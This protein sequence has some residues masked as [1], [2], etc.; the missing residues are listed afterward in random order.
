[1]GECATGLSCEIQ[2]QWSDRLVLRSITVTLS[3]NHFDK[4]QIKKVERSF[5][6]SLDELSEVIAASEQNRND[7]AEITTDSCDNYQIAVKCRCL[8]R[9]KMAI[10]YRLRFWPDRWSY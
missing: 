8:I 2:E 5:T 1:M 6:V 7:C 10:R 3:K 9:S 4:E